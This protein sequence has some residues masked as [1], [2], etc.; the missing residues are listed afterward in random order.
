ML[1][2]QLKNSLLFQANKQEKK[3]SYFLSARL[4]KRPFIAVLKIIFL[5]IITCHAHTTFA[6]QEKKIYGYIEKIT[7]IDSNKIILPAKLDTGAKSASLYAKNIKKITDNGIEYVTFA[8][9]TKHG[10][11]LFKKRYLGE[12]KIKVRNG[13]RRVNPLFKNKI[14]RP[15][16]RMQLKLAGHERSIRV[17][18]ADRSHFSYPLL[19]GRDAII[20]FG[21]VVDPS[22]KYTV[23]STTENQ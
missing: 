23:E 17:N 11:I 10:D 12:V 7:I 13:E 1:V 20:A 16:I 15:L 22:L 3:I 18:L 21:G 4:K 19:L 2:A 9:P 6:Q 14:S 5:A 8:V